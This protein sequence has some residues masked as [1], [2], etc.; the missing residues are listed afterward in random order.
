MREGSERQ[1]VSDGLC[2]KNKYLLHLLHGSNRLLRCRFEIKP[3]F[4]AGVPPHQLV[5]SK[6]LYPVGIL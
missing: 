1:L 2:P 3:C 5:I 6:L 4:F